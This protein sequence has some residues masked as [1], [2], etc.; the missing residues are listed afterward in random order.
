MILGYSSLEQACREYCSDEDSDGSIGMI[1][2]EKCYQEKELEILEK[3]AELFRYLNFVSDTEKL[4]LN[5]NAVSRSI[6]QKIKLLRN[7]GYNTLKKKVGRKI[8]DVPLENI[9][10][11]NPS[12]IGQVFKSAYKTSCNKLN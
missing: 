3:T 8:L 12:R 11:Y 5:P 4:R 9:G 10:I 6:P 7:F 1:L 2:A